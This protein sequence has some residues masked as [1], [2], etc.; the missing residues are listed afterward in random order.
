MWINVVDPILD[1]YMALIFHLVEYFTVSKFT[2][3]TN[4]FIHAIENNIVYS[5]DLHML[6][7]YHM[8]RIHL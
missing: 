8:H 6:N 2:W 3:K 1:L 5:L 4:I 7:I